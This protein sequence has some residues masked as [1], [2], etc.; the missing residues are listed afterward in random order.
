MSREDGQVVAESKEGRM[1]M[2]G[3]Q[4]MKLPAWFPPLRAAGSNRT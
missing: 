1:V 2:G 4:E 3:A